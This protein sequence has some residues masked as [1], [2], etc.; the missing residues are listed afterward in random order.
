MKPT[1]NRFPVIKG[2]LQ[3]GGMPLTRLAERVG[4]TPFFVYERRLL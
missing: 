4:Q 2:C 1:I 3:V